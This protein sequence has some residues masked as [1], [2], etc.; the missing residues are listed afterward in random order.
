MKAKKKGSPLIDKIFLWIN[1]V[2]CLALFVSYL[3][4]ITDPQKHWYIAF[5]GL[6]YPMLLLSNVL[7]MIYWAFRKSWFVL[8]SL[9]TILCGIDVLNNNI[10]F[11][12]GY[13]QVA[14]PQAPNNIRMLTYN[15]HS[16]KK[17]GSHKDIPTK[18]EILTIIN[19]QQPDIIGIQEF[20]TR[21]RGEYDMVDSIKKITGTDNYYFERLQ[22]NAYESMGMVIFS[23]FPIINTGFIQLSPDHSNG[24]Q[25]LYIDVK[26]NDRPFRV[27]SVHLQSIRF[28]QEDYLYLDEVSK[29]GI[30]DMH[31]T[32]RLGGKL[33]KAFIKRS[34]QVAKIKAHARQCP[35]PYIISGDFND[36]P[37][38]YAVNQ[39]AKGLRNAFREKGFGLGRTYNGDFPNYQIDYIMATPQFNVASYTITEKKLSDHYPVCADL[40]LR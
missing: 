39:M 20:Y 29:S 6:A 17:F 16:F 25:C 18:H 33:K 30:G 32:R 7:M 27:Y 9:L 21:N 12:P 1:A 23:R 38:S 34:E 15:V 22:G 35:Y 13:S 40:V 4:P 10:G 36:T 14:K 37:T 24:N 2:L 19:D 3:A 8:L 11:H 5:F 26:K 28:E 31:S